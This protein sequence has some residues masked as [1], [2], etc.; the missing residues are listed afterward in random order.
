MFTLG[1]KLAAT[2]NLYGQVHV[3]ISDFEKGFI[4]L[5]PFSY[6]YFYV[7]EISKIW[8]GLTTI[9][10]EKWRTA[11]VNLSVSIC[12]DWPEYYFCLIALRHSI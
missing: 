5:L 3:Y 2:E 4:M 8:V 1:L 10:A 7:F 11:I 12:C 9:N 6:A